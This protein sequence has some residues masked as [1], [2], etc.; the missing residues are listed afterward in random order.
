MVEPAVKIR[1]LSRVLLV[2][3]SL[4]IIVIGLA[5]P[6]AWILLDA[7]ADRRAWGIP[8]HV[9]LSSLNLGLRMAGFV[10]SGLL[11]GP[12]LYGLA[13]LWLVLR[14]FGRGVLFDRGNVARLRHLGWAIV[15]VACGDIAT[16]IL[17]PYLLTSAN[18]PGQ[19][20]LSFDCNDGD[21]LG[22]FAGGVMLLIAR[23]LDA[24]REIS[25]DNAQ[26]I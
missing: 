19:R 16:Q 23:V 13:Q 15:A 2:F 1:R 21:L 25:E 11:Y 22:L 4:G 3:C 14:Q 7:E 26:I 10:V 9:S 20:F 8:E 18:P 17:V 5:Y 6:L 12:V 24:A